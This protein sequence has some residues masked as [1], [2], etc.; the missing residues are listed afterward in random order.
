MKKI[1]ILILVLVGSLQ[2]VAQTFNASPN[3][4]I[5]DNGQ[6]CYTIN[7]TGVGTIDGLYGLE[8][9]CIDIDHSYDGDLDI[10]LV[11]PDGTSVELTTDNGGSS[12]DYN[13]TCFEMSAGTDVTAGSAPFNGSY[14]PEG[15]LA[16]VNNGQNADGNWQLCIT[17]DAGGDDGTFNSWS[18]TFGNSPAT[19]EIL[20]GSGINGNTYT[21]CDMHIYDDGGASGDYSDNIDEYIIICSGSP[22]TC[23][24]EPE[25]TFN[26]FDLE[27]NADYIYVYDGNSTSASQVAGSPFTGS[28]LPP[29]ITATGDCITIEFVTDNDMWATGDDGFDISVSCTGNPPADDACTNATQI[30]NLEN[31]CGNTSSQYTAGE[32]P[33]GFCGSV[34]NNSWVTF[35]ASA[36][37]ATLDVEVSNCLND[38]GIQMEIYETNDCSNFTSVSNCESPGSVQDFTITATGLT[39]GQN[40]YLMIDGFAGDVCD[41]TVNPGSGVMTADAIV[42][43]TGVNSA[44]TCGGCVHLDASGGTAYQWS[45][46]AGLDDANIQ[47]PTACPTITTTYTVTVTGGNPNCPNSATASVTIDVSDGFDAAISSTPVTCNGGSD[48]SITVSLSNV[49][50]ATQFTYA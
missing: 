42:T 8:T 16:N 50:T 23:P 10:F 41:Y 44:I 22:A 3:A 19:N 32:V 25:L 46:A 38:D 1:T 39:P 40:Y 24:A 28:T 45:P 31:L 34:E 20:V 37:S 29:T 18:I 21:G 48:A 36:S 15:D 13:N 11:A 26:A 7:V 43:E 27:D 30:C 5:T 12:D 17:D 4:N 2:L 14:V 6:H 49:G 9:V 35:T 33:S 47:T